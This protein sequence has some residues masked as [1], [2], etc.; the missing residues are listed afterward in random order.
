[1]RLL[2]IM[3]GQRKAQLT[4]ADLAILA[5]HSEGMSGRD[6]K[7]WV[8]NAQKVAVNRAVSEGGAKF[9]KLTGADMLATVGAIREHNR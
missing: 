9:Y 8:A 1:V 6:I 3:L 2:E 4:G 5:E 7:N